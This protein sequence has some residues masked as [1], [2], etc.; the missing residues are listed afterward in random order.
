M[1]LSEMIDAAMEG[2]SSYLDDFVMSVILRYEPSQDVLKTAYDRLLYERLLEKIDDHDRELRRQR[3]E[4]L[5]D[6]TKAAGVLAQ[7]GIMSAIREEW[8]GRE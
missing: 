7:P 1:R 3:A 4:A 2:D 5:S 8:K 6:T